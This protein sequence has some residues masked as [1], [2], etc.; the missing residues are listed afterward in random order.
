M[1][2]LD[3]EIRHVGQQD[4]EDDVDLKCSHQPAAPFR[5]SNLRNVHGSEH[6]AAANAEAADDAKEKQG[7]PIP[8]KR[9]ANGRD[10]VRH[11]ENAQGVAMADALAWM[12]ANIAP[13]TVPINA[14]ETVKP[15]LT[16]AEC[17]NCVSMC[18]VPAM[19][20]VS[21]PKSRPPRAPTNV[22]RTR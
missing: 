22:P 19:T 16:A 7:I 11:G 12:P 6:G 14:L 15:K 2:C 21:K 10:Y 4:A 13:M 1:E 3:I 20:A 5:R 9:A 8:R 17:E 18:V